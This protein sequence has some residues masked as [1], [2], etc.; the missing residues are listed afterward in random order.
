MK[1]F[2]FDF[3]TNY[4]KSSINQSKHT[5]MWRSFLAVGLPGGIA[6]NVY[7]I[8]S[9]VT[10]EHHPSGQAPPQERV[11]YVTSEMAEKIKSK[12]D[13]PKESLKNDELYNKFI[14]SLKMNETPK[15]DVSE[16]YKTK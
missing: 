6:A 9:H 8:R 4:F 11:D 14:A 5:K 16:I 7:V 15:F 3:S 2:L 1:K 10:H 13:E 12:I